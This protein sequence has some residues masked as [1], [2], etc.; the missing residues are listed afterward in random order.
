MQGDPMKLVN[1]DTKGVVVEFT[2]SKIIFH[3]RFLEA[4][5][6]ENGITVPTAL[7]KEYGNKEIVFVEDSEFL[8]AFKEIYYPSSMNPNVFQWED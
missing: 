3:D 5:M 4:E 2:D 7:Q 6:S 8:K 1:K